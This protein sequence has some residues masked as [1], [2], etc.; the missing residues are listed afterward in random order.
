MKPS[1]GKAIRTKYNGILYRSRT[2][3]RWAVF[4]DS[5]GIKYLYESEGF[6]LSGRWY[7]QT[8]T[9]TSRTST[10][11]SRTVLLR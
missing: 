1:S 9:G 8:S 11:E 7:L 6:D 4:F 10:S 3:A 5:L 2:E